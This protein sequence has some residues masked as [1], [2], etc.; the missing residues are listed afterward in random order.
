LPEREGPSQTFLP[1]K[2]PPAA[3]EKLMDSYLNSKNDKKEIEH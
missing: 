3:R 2:P 1:Y